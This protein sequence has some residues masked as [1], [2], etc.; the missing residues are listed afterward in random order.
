MSMT[1][2][3]IYN[4]Q[5]NTEQNIREKPIVLLKSNSKTS[6]KVEVKKFDR[7]YMDREEHTLSSLG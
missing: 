4:I 6:G 5:C 7:S 1:K 2:D 3:C